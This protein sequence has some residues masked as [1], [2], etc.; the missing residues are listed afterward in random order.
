MFVCRP[1]RSKNLEQPRGARSKP[2]PTRSPSC[3]C[4]GTRSRLA[5]GWACSTNCACS[6][7]HLLTAV[8]L[9]TYDSHRYPPHTN[10]GIIIYF[11]PLYPAARSSRES[12]RR[13]TSSSTRSAPRSCRP[14][15]VL[16]RSLRNGDLRTTHKS[17]RKRGSY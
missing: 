11:Q 6:P 2:L 3:Q 17:Y 13:R 7:L 8:Y 15:T 1:R 9:M 12:T 14:V 5:C 16:D 10:N 4:V